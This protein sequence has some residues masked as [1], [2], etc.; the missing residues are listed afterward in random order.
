MTC[1]GNDD[2]DCFRPKQYES[3]EVY[4]DGDRHRVKRRTM[5]DMRRQTVMID[6]GDIDEENLWVTTR[7]GVGLR[8]EALKLSSSA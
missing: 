1:Y 5:R 7:P 4:R 3:S 8:C 6:E 2:V